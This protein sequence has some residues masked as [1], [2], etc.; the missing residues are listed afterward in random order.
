MIWYLST[1]VDSAIVL[2]V[3]KKFVGYFKSLTRTTVS[4]GLWNYRRMYCFS[5]SL[6]LFYLSLDYLCL[7]VVPNTAKK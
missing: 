6:N 2:E 5:F 1:S 3:F 7:S 4:Y